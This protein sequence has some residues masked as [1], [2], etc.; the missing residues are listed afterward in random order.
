MPPKE[1]IWLGIVSFLTDVSSEMIFSVLTVFMSAVLG[2]STFII[3][4]MEGLADFAASSLDYLS[5]YLSDKSGKRKAFAV[6]G[7][8]FSTLAKFILVFSSTVAG[9]FTFRIVERLGKSVR[10]APR[11]AL[12]STIAGDKN[13]GFSFGFHKMMDKAGAILGPFIGYAILSV[14]GQNLAAFQV[15]FQ[16]AIIPALLS[17][18]ILVFFV[19]EQKTA[20]VKVRENIF[21]NFRGLGKD[22]HNYLKV[23]GLFSLAYFSFAFLLLKA[24]SVGFDLKDVA[25]LYAFFNVSFILISIPAG[26]LGDRFGRRKVI[27]AEYLI[28]L[29]MCV[30]FALST[31]KISVILLFL[32]YGV[33]YALDEAQTK[34]YISDISSPDHRASAIG[35]YNFVTGIIYL[36]ASLLA[37]WLWY[38]FNPSVAFA[39]AGV[40][41]LCSAILFLILKPSAHVKIAA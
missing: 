33:F 19:R 8:G 25:L 17:V 31:D 4:T 26:K 18:L 38:A 30:G 21:K 41:A 34:A 24:N 28:Y 14:L 40:I 15:L 13:L 3:G 10:G 35:V 23:A 32:V 39:V 1:I 29:V 11:D 5:G 22:F 27:L 37:G 6:F 12:I 9:V 7:Y 16:V 36:P 20:T 2:A